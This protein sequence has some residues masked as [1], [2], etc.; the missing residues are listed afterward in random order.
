MKFKTSKK[1]IKNYYHYII[2]I[3]YCQ[4]QTLLKYQQPIAYSSGVYGWSCDYYDIDGVLISSGYGPLSSKNTY[5]TYNDI[6]KF[7]EKAQKLD[8]YKNPYQQRKTQIND[9]LLKMIKN[10]TKKQEA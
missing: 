8:H 4:A 3:G 10:A 7:E 2:S 6:K 9:L 1:N 5:L